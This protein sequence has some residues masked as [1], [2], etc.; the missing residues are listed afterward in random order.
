MKVDYRVVVEALSRIRIDSD[1][2]ELW[3]LYGSRFNRAWETLK[4]GRV[5]KYVFRP[6]GRVVWI[7]VG[8][9]REYLIYHVVGY[10]S[11]DDFYFSV[12]DGKAPLC[13]HLIARKLA[14][15]LGRFEAVEQ[16][17]E[18]YSSHLKEWTSVETER[19][20]VLL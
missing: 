11:C 5:K 9:D 12:I 7:V 3:R 19:E 8:R 13:H 16:E 20:E 6:S 18:F 2:V 4:D 10:C 17:D 1:P 14:E 15:V